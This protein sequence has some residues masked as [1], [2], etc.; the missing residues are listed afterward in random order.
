M[1]ILDLKKRRNKRNHTNAI[2][3]NWRTFEKNYSD[4]MKF[5]KVMKEL[6][7]KKD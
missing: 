5:V 4:K 6:Q 2:D 1:G 7:E 3:S